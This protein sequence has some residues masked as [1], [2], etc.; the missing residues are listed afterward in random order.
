MAL[1]SLP[2]NQTETQTAVATF[3][4]SA[5]S[6]GRIIISNFGRRS[7]GRITNNF[8]RSIISNHR[9]GHKCQLRGFVSLPRGPAYAT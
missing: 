5:R 4:C 8:G 7:F 1:Y 9:A 6:F 3:G 2:S